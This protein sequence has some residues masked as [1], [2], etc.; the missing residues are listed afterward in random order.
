MH[1]LL[2]TW[3]GAGTVPIDMGIG[4]R[5]VSHGH[6]VTVLGDPTIA[7]EADRAGAE[8][9]SWREAPHRRST[10]LEDDVLKDWEV[11][12]NPVKLFR[13]LSERL[14]TGP[15]AAYAKETQQELE[16]RPADVAVVDAA[17][18]GPFVATE[19]LGVPTVGVCPGIYVLPA[20]GMPPFGLGLRPARGPAGRARDTAINTV[21]KAAWRSGLPALNSARADYG[22]APLKDPWDQLRSCE[23]VLVTTARAFDFPAAVPPRVE[24]VGPVMDDPLWATAA[25]GSAAPGQSPGDPADPLGRG[26][27]DDDLPLVVVGVSGSFVW[28]Q[29]DMLRR[30]AAAL[31][32]LPVRGL[33][34]TGPTV[35]PEDVPGSDRV[36]VVRAAPHSEVFPQAS[37]VV[38]HGGHG[39]ITKALAHGKPVLCLPGFRDQ[40]DNAVRMTTRGAGLSLKPSA[41]PAAIA[42]ALRRLLEEPQFTA[43]AAELGSRIRAEM[44]EDRLIALLESPG[45]RSRVT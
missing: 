27:T 33:V 42:R 16:R 18:L 24:Y 36:R 39:T 44:D 14:I 1:Y 4:R 8:F 34:C 7:G 37:V 6:T 40:K 9:V 41:S 3:D 10:A 2:A 17:I 38:T 43:A 12:R 22:L 15:A 11:R 30:I 32:S 19:A 29:D 26:G 35:A 5:L 20:A 28:G 21:V 45:R 23:S 25:P 31:A 13:R